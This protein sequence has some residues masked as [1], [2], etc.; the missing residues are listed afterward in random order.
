MTKLNHNEVASLAKFGGLLVTLLAVLAGVITW[1]D[2]RY[3]NQRI[4]DIYRVQATADLVRAE[5][6]LERVIDELL[7]ARSRDFN[8]LS[9]AI[10]NAS[11]TG[12]VIRRDILLARGR[13]NLTPD[14]AS[15]LEVIELKMKEI[16]NRQ[17][18]IPEP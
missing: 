6:D 15:E 9:L 12:I 7:Q 2:N 18:P 4:F 5:A 10:R 3:V 17:G 13:D 8:V 11:L 1:A 14:E 16:K